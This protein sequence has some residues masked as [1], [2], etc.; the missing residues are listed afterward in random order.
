[1][2]KTIMVHVVTVEPVVSTTTASLFK[3][4]SSDGAEHRGYEVITPKMP[5]IVAS[6]EGINEV[7][8]DERSWMVSLCWILLLKMVC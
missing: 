8:N 7:V 1:V 2:A 4:R 6:K 5:T 3:F